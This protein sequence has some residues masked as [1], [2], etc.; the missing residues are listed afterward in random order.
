MIWYQKL[1]NGCNSSINTKISITIAIC[2]LLT[3]ATASISVT[4]PFPIEI[5]ASLFLIKIQQICPKQTHT[6]C[7]FCSWLS[8]DDINCN[9]NQPIPL[10]VYKII[11]IIIIECCV[12]FFF[13]LFFFVISS[14]LC[15]PFYKS[16]SIDHSYIVLCVALC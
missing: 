16:V 6:Q 15:H 2:S 9:N 1:S 14:F 4:N 12:L 10:H 5:N 7:C 13:S 8:S 11:N 3:T